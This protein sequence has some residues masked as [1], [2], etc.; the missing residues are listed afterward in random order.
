M[1][2]LPPIYAPTNGAEMPEIPNIPGLVLPEVLVRSQEQIQ[3]DEIEIAKRIAN[4][5]V[6]KSMAAALNPRLLSTWI[7]SPREARQLSITK[8][9][10]MLLVIAGFDW[11]PSCKSLSRYLLA[12]PAFKNFTQTN[13]L[14]LSAL[15]VPS[16]SPSGE[17]PIKVAEFKAINKYR[18]FLRVR[19]LP[20]IIMFDP[21]GKE[22]SRTSGFNGSALNVKAT[23]MDKMTLITGV[24][25]KEL[26]RLDKRD[27]NRKTMRE[28][29]NYRDWTSTSG[30]TLFAK[31]SGRALL[32]APSDT[33]SKA[34]VPAAI[35]M[36]E[37]GKEHTVAHTTLSQPD[38]EHIE[39][40]W[41]DRDASTAASAA[42]KAPVP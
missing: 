40:Y 5:T 12:H 32:E 38:V 9:R 34:T 24:M 39:L 26:D 15:N 35:L 23:L 13:Q 8:Q 11:S 21:E 7:R 1:L 27:I 41:A 29:Q 6:P 25:E 36:D 10:P 28:N 16:K 14:V 30:T 3:K 37:H 33:D 18:S 17:N 22:L 19:G 42:K 20:T 4:G 31:I 2:S